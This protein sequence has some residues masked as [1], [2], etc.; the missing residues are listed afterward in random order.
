MITCKLLCHN[1]SIHLAQIYTG[2]ALLHRTGEIILS[3]EFIS[4]EYFE[5]H[6]PQH[7][8]DA[9]YVHLL[10][11]VNDSIKLYYDCHDSHEIDERAANEVDYYFKRSYVESKIADSFKRKVFPLG[12]NY[13][14]YSAEVDEF[15]KQRV[16]R[17]CPASSD[18]GF[19]H[20]VANIH[21]L[22]DSTR[23]PKALFMT[24]AWDP[25]DNCERSYEKRAERMH[26]NE[27]RARCI[28]VLREQ[29]GHRFLGGFTHT[30]YAR[31][32][33]GNLLLENE[34]SS[35]EDYYKLLGDYPICVATTGL[36]GSIGW[37]VGEYVAFSKAIVSERLNHLVSGEFA[38][39]R[40]YLEFDDPNRCVDE[41]ERLFSDAALRDRIMNNNHDYYLKCLRP[42]SMIRRTLRIALKS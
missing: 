9:K 32:H 19:R 28:E 23:E 40:N 13:L 42:D 39:G 37:K 34:L 33:Y 18:Q 36:H 3:Q 1:D 22:P 7:L 21:A 29:F 4:Q 16:S 14:L 41:V 8:R 12:L 5:P 6:Q 27:T 2:F 11:I 24:R 26:L 10:V 17:F 30:D 31:E 35:T 38:Q 25:L 20:T 15:E